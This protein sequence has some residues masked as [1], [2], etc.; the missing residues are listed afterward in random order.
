MMLRGKANRRAA[1]EEHR[2]H[3]DQVYQGALIADRNAKLS[4]FC[5][6]PAIYAPIFNWIAELGGTVILIVGALLI[7]DRVGPY[8]CI[9]I[10]AA[11][12]YAA[13]VMGMAS[14]NMCTMQM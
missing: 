4:I 6:R 10:C 14:I 13:R 9:S 1:E 5:T 7:D 3:L 8:P 11:G 2:A 12:G